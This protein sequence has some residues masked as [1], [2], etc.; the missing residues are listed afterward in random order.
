MQFA[1][2]FAVHAVR[3]TA[4]RLPSH[5]TRL[6]QGLLV[7]GVLTASGMVAAE[8]AAV[9]NGKAIPDTRVESFV[10]AMVAQG[11]PDSPEL[12][13]AVRDELVAR[14]LFVQE[15]EKRSLSATG[16]VE[17]QLIRARQDI[18]IGALIRDQLDKNPVTDAEIQKEFD[19]AA[20][21]QAE[22]KEYRAR[23][24]LVEDEATAKKI[25]SDLDKG[26]KFE[27]LATQ[28]KD[29]GSAARGGDLD[30]N[31]PATFVPEFSTAM[32][33]LEKG[34]YTK[35]PVKSQFGYHVIFLEDTRVAPPPSLES[36][37][38]QIK[39]QLERQRVVD[40]QKT[41]RDSAKIE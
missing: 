38:P 34:K 24:I 17:N 30:W 20:K 31:T 18:L 26:G 35:S 14:E 12:R 6:G 16:D 8:N 21:D 4:F 33:A 2:P 27:E 32:T 41:L 13:K 37:K 9:V 22:E 10:K 7:A 3:A 29:P 15:A 11:R 23:H 5:L 40:L 25:I 36:V 19:A 1:K 39:Q 28:S